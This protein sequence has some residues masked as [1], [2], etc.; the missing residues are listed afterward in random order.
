MAKSRSRVEDQIIAVL[1]EASDELHTEEIAARVGLTRHTVSKYLQ[2]LNAKG[3]VRLRQVGNAKLW[4]E[5]TTE[6]LIRPLTCEDLRPIIQIEKRLQQDWRQEVASRSK[7]QLKA[8]LDLLTKAVEYHLNQ[9]DEQL[10][11]GAEVEH[12][13]VGYIIGEIRLWE[14]GVGEEVGWIKVMSVDPDFQQRNIGRQLGESLLANMRQKGIR[15]VR[16]LPDSYSGEMI[17]FFRSLGFR[18]FT[19][20]P[21]ELELGKGGKQSK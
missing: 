16:T 6:V 8:Q 9:T 3:S 2:V 14:F 12:Q 18:I 15:R 19:G 5:A 10:R 4:R 1:K 21:M 20:M 7:A 11:L 17:S 13:L